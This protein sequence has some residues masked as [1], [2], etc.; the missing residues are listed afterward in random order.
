MPFRETNLVFNVALYES[1]HTECGNSEA[2]LIF[3]T[4]FTAQDEKMPA[5][6]LK[7]EWLMYY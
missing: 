4:H 1:R 7:N 3:N 5:V 2:F 6:N